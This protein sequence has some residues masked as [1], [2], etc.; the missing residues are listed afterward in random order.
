MQVD[1][2]L[3][4]E[5]Y[6]KIDGMFEGL[7]DCADGLFEPK[8]RCRMHVADGWNGPEWPDVTFI[9]FEL[10]GMNVL[11]YNVTLP[12]TAEY[13]SRLARESAVQERRHEPPMDVHEM[14]IS[15]R[16]PVCSPSRLARV[17]A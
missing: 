11:R 14:R 5:D 17:S 3:Y 8:W 4:N 6:T 9:H 2:L 15:R 10:V 1:Y 12:R 7:T 16:H 13:P